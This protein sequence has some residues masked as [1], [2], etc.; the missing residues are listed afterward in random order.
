MPCWQGGRTEPVS[1]TSCCLKQIIN[2]LHE[3]VLEGGGGV[4]L[5][6]VVHVVGV[7]GV[8][9]V[10]VDGGEGVLDIYISII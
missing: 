1:R 10:G 9:E 4:L 8:L 6:L 2:P 5:G 3:L 7:H